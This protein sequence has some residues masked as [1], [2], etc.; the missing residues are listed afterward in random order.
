MEEN[1]H[2]EKYLYGLNELQTADAAEVKL[3]DEIRD[4]NQK[5]KGV[6]VKST[7]NQLK[8][9]SNSSVHEES[10]NKERLT[11][12]HNESTHQSRKSRPSSFD[13]NSRN[14]ACLNSKVSKFT[15]NSKKI[16]NT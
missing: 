1:F 5:S 15:Q 16:Q 7:T 12:G 2:H 13:I 4:L 14:K 8:H 11:F 9:R 3:S 6:T 10:K